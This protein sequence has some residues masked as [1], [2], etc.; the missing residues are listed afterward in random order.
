MSLVAIG[1]GRRVPNQ[2]SKMPRIWAMDVTNLEQVTQ[3]DLNLSIIPSQKGIGTPIGTGD[4]QDPD[5]HIIT[6][7]ED[8]LVVIRNTENKSP[9]NFAIRFYWNIWFN[10]L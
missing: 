1:A 3:K 6:D 2:I 10:I 4:P 7:L 8:H 9:R 5:P